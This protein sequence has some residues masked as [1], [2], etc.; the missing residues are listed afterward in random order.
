MADHTPVNS[1]ITDAITQ[2]NLTVLGNAPAQ[3]MSN[4]YQVLAQSVGVSMQNAVTNQQSMNT[5]DTAIV[6]QGVNMLYALDST[7]DAKATQE[8]MTGNVS[9]EMVS[10]LKAVVNSIKAQ[11]S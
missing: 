7:A 6:A 3:S 10:A 4:V 5:I 8:I 1:Q 2:T 11:K 9:A